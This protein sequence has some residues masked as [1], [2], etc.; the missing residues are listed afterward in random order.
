M[1]TRL[2]LHEELCTLL[3]SRNCYFEPPES[4]KLNYPCFIYYVDDITQIRADNRHYLDINEYSITYITS[5]PNSDICEK[6]FEAFPTSRFDRKYNSDN[7][8]HY[9]FALSY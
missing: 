3:G 4:I 8:H 5:K 2:N 9:V 6:F 1:A 7:L